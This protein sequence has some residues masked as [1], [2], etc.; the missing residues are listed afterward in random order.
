M[1]V[2]E[3]ELGATHGLLNIW[4]CNTDM[5]VFIIQTTIITNAGWNITSRA[6]FIVVL[7]NKARIQTIK[8]K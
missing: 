2:K 5:H 8:N 3:Q 6:K 4:T 1:T 7:F